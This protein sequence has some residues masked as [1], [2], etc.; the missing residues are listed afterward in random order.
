MA[1]DVRTSKEDIKTIREHVARAKA[2]SGRLDVLK[3]LD[4]LVDALELFTVT[5]IV[6]REKFE[7]SILID[8]V[9]RTLAAM[10][11]LKALFPN[12]ASLAKGQE[13]QM[14][15]RLAA[16]R[17]RIR[18]AIEK[19]EYEK[20]YAYKVSIDQALIE[21]M[22]L[23]QEG[24][25]DQARVAFRKAADRF[26]SE[27]G[28]LQDVGAR[29]I[30]CGMVQESVEYLEQAIKTDPKDPRPYGHLVMA[31]EGLGEVE[32]ALEITKDALRNFG[33]ND[34]TY[35]IMARLHLKLKQW[36]EAFDMASAALD[37]NP[38]AKEAQ[39][40]ADKVKPRI[41]SKTADGKVQDK[42]TYTFNL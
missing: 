29:M 40:I 30:R 34:R 35:T 26:V 11:Q 38:F 37:L 8:E 7:I 16:I 27:P 22:R 39:K 31:L 41:F 15:A 14:L 28:L 42:K 1:E 23:A 13:K 25:T 9:L 17:D 24:Q 32:K 20:T 10:P 36:D 12:G 5:Q 33:P 19:A 18:T 4:A 21:A 2:Y 3:T 6:G